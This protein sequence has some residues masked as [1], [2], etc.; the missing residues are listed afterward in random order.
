MADR[1]PQA[2]N[3]IRRESTTELFRELVEGAVAHQRLTLSAESIV[4]L[5]HVLDAFT[6]PDRRW[7]EA[8]AEPDRSLAELALE[9]FGSDRHRRAL[10]LRLVGD[11]SLFLSGF[12]SDAL[13]RSAVDVDY[14]IR[15][16]GTAYS[17][18]AEIRTHAAAMLYAELA[19]NFVRFV[20]V[21]AEVSERC[22][23]TDPSDLLR[24]VDRWRR[25]RSP[26]DGRR[27]ERYGIAVLSATRSV[28]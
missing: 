13:A 27:L 18:I 11:T 28:H 21:L 25:S 22:A 4:Y 7:A 17:R 15:L 19:E 26:R 12:Q 5:V 8:G 24:L 10:L 3:H 20:D 14:Y 23:L 6:R 1:V 9:A 16:G 2:A